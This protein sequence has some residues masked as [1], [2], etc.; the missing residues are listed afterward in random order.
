MMKSL[1]ILAVYVV[2]FF[3]FGILSAISLPQNLIILLIPIS[4]IGPVLPIF[5]VERKFPKKRKQLDEI[6]S[7]DKTVD[8]PVNSLSLTEKD[9][10]LFLM[11]ALSGNANTSLFAAHCNGFKEITISEDENEA[12]YAEYSEFSIQPFENPNAENLK[13]ATDHLIEEVSTLW[14]FPNN[15]FNSYFFKEMFDGNTFGAPTEFVIKNEEAIR[16]LRAQIL[17]FDGSSLSF[18]NNGED[19]DLRSFVHQFVLELK[20][21]ELS[22]IL[23]NFD[24]KKTTL[25]PLFAQVKNK[26]KN[27]YGDVDT[28]EFKKEIKEFVDYQF[29]TEHFSFF[30]MSL[31]YCDIIKH[32]TDWFDGSHQLGSIPEDGI[33]FEYWCAE[34]LRKQGWEAT[35]SK[36]SG[37]QGVDILATQG[38]FSV[39]IQCKRYANPIGNKAVQEVFSGKANLSANAA[40]VIGTGGFTKSATELAQATNVTLLDVSQID[41][42][43]KLV[44]H[45]L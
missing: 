8:E 7:V 16:S 44:R 36:A 32:I 13:F 39:A 31:P 35:V 10:Q 40:V 9:L 12:K 27:K 18:Q 11:A 34:V 38:E 26:A 22:T 33:A 2:S 3:I 45:T 28:S 15:I 14:S 5:M 24:E 20:Q 42:F 43:S 25:K 29:G 23:S 4:L 17:L 6:I 19:I 30:H 21:N 37:D 41:D 1:R